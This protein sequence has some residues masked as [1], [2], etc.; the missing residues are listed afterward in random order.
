[1]K[2]VRAIKTQHISMTKASNEAAIPTPQKRVATRAWVMWSITAIFVLF[3]FFLQ[4][5]SGEVITGLMKSFSLSAL[6]GGV[7]ASAYYYIYVALQTPAGILVDRFGPR[8]LLTLGALVC[9]CGCFVFGYADSLWFAIVGRLLMGGGAAFAFV[10]SL[11]VIAKWFPPQHFAIM[12]AIAET[13]GMIGTIVGGVFLASLVQQIGWRSS[14]MGAAGIGFV[15]A[16]LLWT[17]VRD[18]KVLQTVRI[19]V[20]CNNSFWNDLKT[21]LKSSAAWINGIYSGLL[22]SV[23]TVFVA[24]WAIPY[25]Q[26]AHHISLAKATICCD[27]M[28]VGIALGGP[29]IGWLDGRLRN[30][31]FILT[32]FPCI[33]AVLLSAVIYLTNLPMWQIMILMPL[34]GVFTSVYVL[35][36]CIANEIMPPYMSGTSMGFVNMISVGSAPLF[37]PLIGLFLTLVVGHT[38]ASA[39]HYTV[40]DY[41]YA[42]IILPLLVLTAALL[43]CWMPQRR[44]E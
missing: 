1:M 8:C 20:A 31:R 6:G 38:H 42:F 10:G 12:A 43:G 30:R 33:A 25:M 24:L 4:L 18:K 41:Q 36:F 35:T 28:F 37:Q 19:E 5:S 16:A 23:V 34:L 32:I 13:I 14:M 21:L 7:L 39:L 3:Q 40:L 22:F 2:R 11:N 44:Q 15:I 9:A 17:I 26:L 27:L 29:F